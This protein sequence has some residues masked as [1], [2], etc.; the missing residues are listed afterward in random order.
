MFTFSTLD[1][2]KISHGK[3]SEKFNVDYKVLVRL[4]EPIIGSVAMSLY[5]TLESE[6]SLNKYS[7]TTNQIARLHKLTRSD[8]KSFNEAI[9]LLKKYDLL[10]YKANQRKANDYLFVINP[11]RS[12][13]EFFN[14]EKL[15]DALQ[16]MVDDNYYKQVY[17]YFISTM[18]NEDEY[19]DIEDIKIT[20]ELTEDEF[21]LQFMDKYPIIGSSCAITDK[22]KKEIARLKKLF[23]LSFDKIE[24]AILNSFDYENN[25]MVINLEM[26]NDFISNKYGEEHLSADEKV[27]K[28]FE[29]ERS[30][31]YYQKLSGRTSLLPR[32]TSMINELLDQYQISEGVLNVVINFYF[33]YGKNTMAPSKN[34]FVKVIE[35]M[36]MNNV[37]TTL[38]AMNYFRNRNKRIKDYKEKQTQTTQASVNPVE[39]IKVKKE[40][41]EETSEIDIDLLNEFKK[42]LGG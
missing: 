28:T 30:I 38:D 5:L 32:E 18:I 31:S 13:I 37:S 12:A 33:R 16:V 2:Y 6:F 26:L 23:K 35:E 7:K 1:T 10:S 19:V 15:N 29:S 9:E 41:V 40:E 8:D 39:E 34:Y 27:A 11:T 17:N 3:K 36:L 14:N 20:K 25:Q 21:Y 24:N 4:Y 22:C 42:A